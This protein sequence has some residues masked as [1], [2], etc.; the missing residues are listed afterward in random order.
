MIFPQV[1]AVLDEF[2][3][4]LMAEIHVDGVLEAQ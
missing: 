2:W 1:G 4:T 3:S